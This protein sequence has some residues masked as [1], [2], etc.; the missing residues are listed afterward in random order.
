MKMF[1]WLKKSTPT[2]VG[3]FG[4]IP[5]EG[6]FISHNA[7]DPAVGVFDQWLQTSID[8][9][10]HAGAEELP[11]VPVRFVF[12]GADP[13]SVLVGVMMPSRDAVGRIFPLTVFA[14][15]SASRLAGKF[16]TIPFLF[17]EFFESATELLRSAEKRELEELA[18]ELDEIEAPDIDGDEDPEAMRPMLQSA[19]SA[20]S[21]EALFGA[22]HRP[23]R[24]YA[25]QT[26]GVACKA[27]QK[28]DPAKSGATIDCPVQNEQDVAFWLNLAQKLLAWKKAPPSIF[29]T[30]GATPRLILSLGPAGAV[31][32][33]SLLR[34]ELD[35][36]KLWSLKTRDTA[37]RDAAKGS[38]QANQQQ[39]IEQDGV[40]NE[41]LIASL[42][43]P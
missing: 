2:S 21:W 37:A 8:K 38:F 6:D 28:E 14:T 5:D 11:S 36:P 31:V 26:F 1:G 4:K 12:R 30:A 9:A 42:A 16:S 39:I 19:R 32:L 43:R 41:A 15:C 35:S 40:S 17:K 22:E 27:V 20:E 7:A 33:L 10:R 18:E 25:F 3:L 13:K 24:F 34:P 29:W 23:S